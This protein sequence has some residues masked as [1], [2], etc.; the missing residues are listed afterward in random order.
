MTRKYHLSFTIGPVQGFVGQARRTRDL[1]A[2]S[3]LLSY[4][5]ESALVA[6]ENAGGQAIIPHRPESV[7]GT[8][9]S[10]QTVTGGIP[11]RFECAFDSR[12][13][14]VKAGE[15]AQ[16]AFTEAWQKVAGAVWDEFVGPVAAQGNG[17]ADIWNRQVANFWE[18]SWVVAQPEGGDTTIGRL[19]AARKAFRNVPA[20]EEAGVKCSLMGTLQEISGHYGDRQKAFWESFKTGAHDLRDGERLCAIAL[21]KRLFPRVIEKAAGADISDDLR[22]Q[23][24]WPSLAFF[25]AIPWLKKVG[26][27]AVDDAKA[28]IQE[29]LAATSA[30]GDGIGRSEQQ[31][32]H[33]AQLSW[34]YVDAPAWFIG[35]LRNNDWDLE[36]QARDNL[37]KALGK[38]YEKVPAG[39]FP[40]YT[41]LVMDGD[42]MGALLGR[43][44]EPSKLSESLG[45]FASGV[46]SIVRAHGGHTVYAGGDDVLALLP[47]K[48]ALPA[49]MELAAKYAACFPRIEEATLSGAIVYAHWKQPM[50]QVVGLGHRLLDERAKH[51]TGRDALAI[52]ITQ[53]SGLN[54]L[55]SAPWKFVRGE[56]G[57]AALP[58]MLE[59]FGG[60]DTD[61]EAA[62]FNAS[63][64][65]NLRQQFSRLFPAVDTHAGAF[66]SVDGELTLFT[67]IAHAEYR[68]RLSKQ[69]RK[70]RDKTAT[71]P[72]VEALLSLSQRVRRVEG[73]P[74]P[75]PATFGFDGWRVARFLK[76]VEDGKVGDHD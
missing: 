36:P 33:A 3:W 56:A 60:D 39:P 2:G 61:T 70:K 25:S 12:E 42:S 37:I 16:E 35:A 21:I 75:E 69:E 45:R 67:D 10:K 41:L 31:A 27:K 55:W 51:E 53:G 26:D 49:A 4:L 19:H 52:G 65:Y 50:Q 71:E 72:D 1:W 8:V 18:T 6:A 9:T 68:R 15:A 59:H 7:R 57:S 40:F 48:G 13:E 54:A 17:T 11:N 38:L 66:G 5:A 22:K 29:A 34:A 44:G 46:D 20:T 58:D 63:Y 28:Y 47:A 14:A 73:K 30:Q 64:L 32:A 62:S 24:S 76:Q 43:L 74:I 23:M